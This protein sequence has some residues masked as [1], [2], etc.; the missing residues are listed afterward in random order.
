[1][2]SSSNV[3]SNMFTLFS[4]LKKWSVVPTKGTLC[5]HVQCGLACT[6]LIPIPILQCFGYERY[7]LAVCSRAGLLV[8]EVNNPLSKTLL[9]VCASLVEVLLE[10]NRSKILP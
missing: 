6:S 4:E 9:E 1:M 2:V 7:N 5:A 3:L 8:L 10:D